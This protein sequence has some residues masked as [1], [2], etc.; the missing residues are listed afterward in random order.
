MA[1]SVPYRSIP[2]MFRQRVAATPD[3]E[4]LGH[5]TPDEQVAWLTWAQVGQQAYAIA[6]GLVGL[7]VRPE[8][9]VAILSSTRVEWILADFG[10]MCAGAATTTVY[11]TTEPEDAQYILN[12]S[13]STVLIAE[14]PRQV[15]KAADGTTGIRHVVIIDGEA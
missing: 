8:D 3:R 14:D 10:I 5:P 9:R 4:A 11:P 12:D 13:G 2:D 7:G 15:A 1:L 6:A